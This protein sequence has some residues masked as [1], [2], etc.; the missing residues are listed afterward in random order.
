MIEHVG[1]LLDLEPGQRVEHGPA[2]VTNSSLHAY[3]MLSSVRWHMWTRL[4][5]VCCAVLVVSGI[6]CD[7]GGA[8]GESGPSTTPPVETVQTGSP[9][10]SLDRVLW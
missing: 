4:P 9:G 8:A 1:H 5:R 10:D 2:A 6:G 7:G 3:R